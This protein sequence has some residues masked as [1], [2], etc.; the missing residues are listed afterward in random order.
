VVLITVRVIESILPMRLIF[1]APSMPKRNDSK[2]GSLF[3]EDHLQTSNRNLAAEQA[4]VL[5]D[6]PP[7]AVPAS[8]HARIRREP[9]PRTA[10]GR[11]W[12]SLF[13]GWA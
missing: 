9:E 12:H 13:K 4:G 6:L 7:S 1:Y 2:Q 5:D 8:F 10:V 11:L 3:G